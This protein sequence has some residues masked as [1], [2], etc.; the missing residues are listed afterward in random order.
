[1]VI[2]PEGS[3]AALADSTEDAMRTLV[4]THG[5]LWEDIRNSGRKPSDSDLRQ[6]YFPLVLAL[7]DQHRLAEANELLE[8]APG[9]DE[10]SPR[11]RAGLLQLRGELLLLKGSPQEG[12]KHLH[13]ALL[14]WRTDARS[15]ASDAVIQG[16]VERITDRLTVALAELGHIDEAIAMARNSLQQSEQRG[17]ILGGTAE[18]LRRLSVDHSRLG[19]LLI[20]KGELVE[21]GRHVAEDLQISHKMLA[22]D[23]E[24]PRAM[25]D[26]GV[27]HLK[28]AE[29]LV[30]QGKLGEAREALNLALQSA[31]SATHLQPRSMQSSRLLAAV[32][33]NL[34]YVESLLG[35]AA[36]AFRYLKESE[37]LAERVA[38]AAPLHRESQ[39]NLVTIRAMLAEMLQQSGSPNARSAWDS[40]AHQIEAMESTG[41]LPPR[42]AELLRL[43]R[44]KTAA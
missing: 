2:V 22:L 34:A 18:L 43:A 29:F 42:E 26:L 3:P 19:E 35:N 38:L 36:L 23:P 5:P 17:S 12:L 7:L 8:Q 37:S 25:A 13:E 16:F 24:S 31:R 10:L 40:L 15:Q 6:I 30:A 20:A 41:A 21:A 14:W 1:L 4:A 33:T 39:S 44:S 11:A 28:S 9:V 27:A 32:L